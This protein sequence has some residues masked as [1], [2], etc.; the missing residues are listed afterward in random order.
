M[1]VFRTIEDV[2][3]ARLPGDL[4]AVVHGLL[5]SI[6]AEY[7]RGGCTFNPDE[8]GHVLL[9]EEGDSDDAVRAALGATLLDA[10]LEGCTYESRTFVGCVQFNNQ[11]IISVLVEDAPWLNPAARARL[12]QNL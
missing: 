12:V 10:V 1:K 2:E 4:H 11:F 8:D 9:I 7:A 3:R 6:I 5:S